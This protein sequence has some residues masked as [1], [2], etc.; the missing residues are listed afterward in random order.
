MVQSK[1]W[2][3]VSGASPRWLQPSEES[4]YLAH[5]WCEKGYQTMLDLGCGLGRHSIFF[6]QNGF[7]VSAMDLSEEGV[8]NLNQWKERE[9]LQIATAVGDML[10][11]PYGDRTFDCVFAYHV[12]S[13]TDTVGIRQIIDEVDRVLAPDGEFYITLCSKET[14]SFTDA[15]YP[16]IDENTV[17]KTE[18]GAEKDVPHF[19]AALDDVLELFGRFELISIRH[20]DNCYFE[21]SKRQG[22]HYFVLGKKKQSDL[23][24]T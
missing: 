24:Q 6:A 16:R 22:K 10:N 18:E 11:L 2:D 14:W 23:K 7:S 3:W 8:R 19:Y 17:L 5:R 15:G 9:G 20:I 13:H 1:A 12:I 21:G 4:Y